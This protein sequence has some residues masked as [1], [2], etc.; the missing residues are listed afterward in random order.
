PP[1]VGVVLARA[2]DRTRGARMYTQA[3]LGP[4]DLEKPYF[5]V[6]EGLGEIYVSAAGHLDSL[7]GTNAFR[8]IEPPDGAEPVTVNFALDPGKSLTGRIEDADGKP[9]AGGTVTG[10][11]PSWARSERRED[12]TFTAVALDPDHPRSIAV[13]HPQRKLAAVAQLRGD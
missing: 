13:I 6:A 9:V 12:A 1:G 8:V 10:L 2:E 4:D 3:H 5:Q 11:G 7:I